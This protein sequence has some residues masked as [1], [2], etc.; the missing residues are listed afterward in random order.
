MI[1]KINLFF[2]SMLEKNNLFF[3]SMLEYIITGLCFIMAC[4][5]GGISATLQEQTEIMKQNDVSKMTKK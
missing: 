4:H 3:F 2:F 5:L 1:F